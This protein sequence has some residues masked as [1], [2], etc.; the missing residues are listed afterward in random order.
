MAVDL[1]FRNVDADVADPVECW[2]VEA[3][4][5]ALERG[6]LRHWSRIVK[7]ISDDPWGPLARDVEQALGYVQA[8]GVRPGLTRALQRARETRE[9]EEKRAVAH[10]FRELVEESGLT[11]AEFAT[12]IGTSGSRLSTYLSGKVTPSATLLLRAR[13][14]RDRAQRAAISQAKEGHGD[15]RY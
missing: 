10:E 15:S 7:A 3:I 12:R 2:P 1:L 11:A 4:A 13:S 9:Q 8:Y 6:G 14:V 5:T